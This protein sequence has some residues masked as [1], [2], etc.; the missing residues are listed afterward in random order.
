VFWRRTAAA[1]GAVLTAASVSVATTSSASAG[2]SP[3]TDSTVF[4]LGPSDNYVAEWMGLSQG[5]TVIGGPASGLYAGSAGVF[6]IDPSSG[7]IE[8]Y[9]GTPGNWTVIGG[10]GQMFAEGGG[11]LYGL[12]PNGAYV[13]E[14]MGLSQGWSVIG[15]P[16]DSIAAGTAGLVET[17]TYSVTTGTFTVYN[18]TISRYS[19]TPGSWTY[20]GSSGNGTGQIAVGY[21]IYKIDIGGESLSEWAGGTTWGTILDDAGHLN[22]M[23][24]GDAGVT[25]CEDAGGIFLYQGS[26]DHWL[27]ISDFPSP[28]IGTQNPVAVSRTGIYGVGYTYGV[29]VTSVDLYSGSGSTWTTIGGPADI[30]AAGD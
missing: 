29:G 25:V 20:I 16:A 17:H 5:W 9:D 7:D 19:G 4:A 11:H 12:G 13:A 23:V 26:L 14:W 30:V 1:A 27:K 2:T 28:P 15:G 6:A 10:P 24:G 3:S 21:T 22:S 8:M 18:Q